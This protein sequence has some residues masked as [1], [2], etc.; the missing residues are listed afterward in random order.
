MDSMCGQAVADE[1]IWHEAKGEHFIVLYNFTQD[2]EAARTVLNTAEQ[3][4]HS[5]ADQIG[6]S[7]YSNF[8][9]WDDRVKI[10]IFPDQETY[11]QMTGAP[12]WSNGYATRDYRLVHSRM[13]VTFRQEDGFLDGVL[14]HEISH[15]I[16]HDFIGFDRPIP[17]WFDEG[18]AQLQEAEKKI[19]ATLIMRKVVS[20]N[21]FIPLVMLTQWDI[22]QEKDSKKVML[23]YIESVALLDYL[24]QQFGSISFGELCRYLKSGKSMEEAL[25]LAYNPSIDSLANLEDRWMRYLKR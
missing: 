1:G 13:I 14:P 12:Q 6:Y 5:I 4:Y 22:R 25:V 19:K 16:L 7:R 23:F 10:I 9:T 8:W 11:M 18:L 24:I 2:D 15:L 21:E 20:H 3:Y 17:I